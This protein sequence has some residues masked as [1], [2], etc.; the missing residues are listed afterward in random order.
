MST[1]PWMGLL[2][3]CG[4]PLHERLAPIREQ[5][6]NEARKAFEATLEIGR[7]SPIEVQCADVG[8]FGI[9]STLV[10]DRE[11]DFHARIRKIEG[12]IDD[13]SG[14]ILATQTPV[15]VNTAS[16]LQLILARSPCRP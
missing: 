7:H 11:L 6:S 8:D 14:N 2:D 12:G 4:H 5:T 15:S 3:P 1:S 13:M 16:D 9:H 10:L